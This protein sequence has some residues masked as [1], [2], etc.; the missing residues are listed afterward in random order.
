MPCDFPIK[1]PWWDEKERK[2]TAPEE[3]FETNPNP[4]EEHQLRIDHYCAREMAKAIR[5][6]NY[7]EAESIARSP[8]VSW[9]T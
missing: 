6:G 5:K 3:L 2:C 7:D 1:C 8:F 4:C 9:S